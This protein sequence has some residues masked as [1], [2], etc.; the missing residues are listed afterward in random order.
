MA[1]TPEGRLKSNDIKGYL[2]TVPNLFLHSVPGGVYGKNGVPDIVCCYKGRYIG[3]E[4]KTYDGTFSGWQRL[5]KA[6]I[7]E[8][9]GICI[10]AKTVD[11]VRD[12]LESL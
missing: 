7:E 11:D 2:K 1:T 12:V 6:Q 10:F 9:G 4:A 5:R 3:I 8:A